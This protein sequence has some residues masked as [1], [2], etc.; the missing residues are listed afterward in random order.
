MDLKRYHIRYHFQNDGVI[1]C[2]VK[3]CIERQTL[4]SSTNTKPSQINFL[5]Q[6]ETFS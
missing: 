4:T 2:D 6:I 5:M 3:I 1:A